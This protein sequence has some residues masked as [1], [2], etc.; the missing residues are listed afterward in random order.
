[1]V[2]REAEKNR[3]RVIIVP[4]SLAPVERDGPAVADKRAVMRTQVGQR[5]VM[6]LVTIS[7]TVD[8]HDVGVGARV[9]ALVI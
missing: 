5:H 3:F 8:R 7:I 6:R 4:K 9:L 1:M 2:A